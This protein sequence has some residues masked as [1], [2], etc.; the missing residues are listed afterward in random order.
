LTGRRFAFLK[1]VERDLTVEKKG[2]WWRCRCDCG[3]GTSQRADVLKDGRVVSC[4]HTRGRH[5]RHQ[6]SR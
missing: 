1:V 4:G 6:E 5:E 3:Q 2:A